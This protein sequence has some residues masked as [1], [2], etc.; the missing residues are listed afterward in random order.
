MIEKRAAVMNTKTEKND[1][2]LS[3]IIEFRETSDP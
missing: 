2:R 3:F 1:V